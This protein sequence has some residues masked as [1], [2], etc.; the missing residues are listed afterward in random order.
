MQVL[1]QGQTCYIKRSIEFLRQQKEVYKKVAKR[2]FEK[3]WF[4]YDEHHDS[5]KVI[6]Y[7]QNNQAKTYLVGKLV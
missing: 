1:N 7:K 3:T 6:A 5:C 2:A 4:D